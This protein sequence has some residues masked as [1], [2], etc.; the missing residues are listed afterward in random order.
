MSESYDWRT[1][2][3]RAERDDWVDYRVA[4][5]VFGR[6]NLGLGFGD[7]S[8]VQEQ[9]RI[10]Y[11]WMFKAGKRRYC[12][13][14]MVSLRRLSLDP[15]IERFVEILVDKWKRE[16][17]AFAEVLDDDTIGPADPS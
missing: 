17:L 2:V 9:T 14:E 7:L 13:E 4:G 10:T 15:S 11:S 16:H 5:E 8:M 12:C 6:L 3:H 1:K